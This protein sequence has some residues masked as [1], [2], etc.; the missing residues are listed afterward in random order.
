MNCDGFAV[1]AREC[2]TRYTTDKDEFELRNSMSRSYYWAYHHA[3]DVASAIGLAGYSGPKTG[4][5]V[6]LSARF[7]AASGRSART[8]G[9]M[10]TLSHK[11]RCLADYELK[12]PVSASLANQQFSRCAG[13][14]QRLD[15]MASHVEQGTS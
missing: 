1:S 11:L 13:I 12:E 15:Q 6:Q 10:L 3:V 14:C 8:I 2:L 4:S 7:S 9:A 5:H